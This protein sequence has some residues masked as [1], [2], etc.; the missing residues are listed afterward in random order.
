[1][2]FGFDLDDRERSQ[3]QDKL[4]HKVHDYSADTLQVGKKL[5]DYPL[6]FPFLQ[7]HLKNHCLQTDRQNFLFSRCHER[8]Y[9]QKNNIYQYATSAYRGFFLLQIFQ[10]QERCFLRDKQLHKHHNPYK[11]LNR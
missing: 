2:P 1:M 7:I 3:Q 5:V 9:L 10:Q 8:K 6:L 4:F 11:H